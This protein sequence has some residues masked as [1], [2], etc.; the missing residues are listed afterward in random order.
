MKQWKRWSIPRRY[1]L[2]LLVAGV[3]L[4]PILG[5]VVEL[6]MPDLELWGELWSGLLP[7]MAINTLVLALTVGSLALVLG[8]SLAWLVSAYDFRG[9]RLL[10][11]LLI[12]PLAVPS[13]VIGFV[14]MA[15]LDYV[16]PIQTQLR[17]W[18]GPAVRIEIRTIWVAALVLAL[19]LYPYV[20][21]TARA[22][23]REQARSG[24]DSARSMGA[25]YWQYLRFVLLPLAR[26]S[27]AAG[28]VLVMMEA[29]TDFATVRFFSVSTLSEGV[30]RLWEGRM[31]RAAAAE[32]AS[33]LLLMALGLF[34]V[35]R[36]LRRGADYSQDVTDGVGIPRTRLRGGAA[37]AAIV[38]PLTILVVAFILPIV[39]LL[40]W[41]IQHVMRSS[42]SAW[43]VVFGRFAA[44]SLGI[45]TVSTL[46]TV[47]VALW[48]AYASRRGGRI[49]GVG[50]SVLRLS[51]VGYAL[52]GTVVAVGVLLILSGVDRALNATAEGLGFN[53]PGLVFTGSLIGL[54][55]A[56]V[57][58]FLAVAFN[59]IEASISK[60]DPALDDVALL[61]GIQPLT[62]ML[63][64][65]LPMISA[66]VISA[67]LLLF[68]D[69]LREL[70]TAL[71]LRPLGMDT[72]AVWSYMA[73][74]ESYWQEAAIPALAIVAVGLVPTYILMRLIDRT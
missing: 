23:F 16:G 19:V 29:I 20:F 46:I 10:E 41:A 58:R 71:L 5:L 6:L 61:Y 28:V 26:P 8:V 69:V 50:R 33:L 54:F 27:L 36:L 9:R 40:A 70:P 30:V 56:Y 1:W 68:V 45:A 22:A 7:K 3:I 44:A 17:A 39:Q 13:F 21:L 42:N 74:S 51:A 32:L 67:A 60:L 25:T 11:K 4:L 64:V 37:I 18:F 38:Y 55:Y 49:G 14:Y 59:P 15:L 53:A 65:H 35:E 66:G 73:A 72:L 63:R 2:P 12:L 24:F 48:F 43:T 52:P 47:S 31:D 57:V 62:N 34:A